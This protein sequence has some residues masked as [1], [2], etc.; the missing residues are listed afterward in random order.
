[1]A[2][3]NSH[4]PARQSAKGD[5]DPRATGGGARSAELLAVSIDMQPYRPGLVRVIRNG[6][7]LSIHY[8]YLN[9]I[10]LEGDPSPLVLNRIRTDEMSEHW[11]EIGGGRFSVWVSGAILV[12]P[13]VQEGARERAMR[14]SERKRLLAAKGSHCEALLGFRING[15]SPELIVGKDIVW[16]EPC[17][18]KIGSAELTEDY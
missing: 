12:H 11:E 17:V 18:L 16:V 9:A 6:V 10:K 14:Q 13:E 4:N 8:I 5:K 15:D 1:M 7:D 3:K 2:K